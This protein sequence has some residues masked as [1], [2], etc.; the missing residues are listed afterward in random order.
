MVKMILEY[1]HQPQSE[2]SYLDLEGSF[3]LKGDGFVPEGVRRVGALLDDHAV[4]S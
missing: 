2:L 1:L 3:F 4:N